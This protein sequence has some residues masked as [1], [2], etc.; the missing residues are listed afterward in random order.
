MILGFFWVE[1]LVLDLI[2]DVFLSVDVLLFQRIHEHVLLSLSDVEFV[3]LAFLF[4]PFEQAAGDPSLV[5]EAAA[6]VQ[7]L[8]LHDVF[9][10]LPGAKGLDLA[11]N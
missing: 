8:K 6:G 9:G 1:P 5:V 10:R 3:F 11:L 7:I 2:L 4:L